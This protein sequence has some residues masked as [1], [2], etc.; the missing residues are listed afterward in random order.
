VARPGDQ[1]AADVEQRLE[2]RR[3]CSGARACRSP[4]ASFEEA[5]RRRCTGPAIERAT[6][7]P[8]NTAAEEEAAAT[9][10]S[11]MSC[12]ELNITVPEIETAA[13]G[14]ATETSASPVRRRLAVGSS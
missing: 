14:S 4:P 10:S 3:P 2:V 9:K 12:P 1:L 11:V 8:A 7:R 5:A 6:R 13:R